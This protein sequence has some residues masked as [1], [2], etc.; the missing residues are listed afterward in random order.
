MPWILLGDMNMVFNQEEKIGGIPFK[1]AN[2]CYYQNIL[3]N[4]GL[5]DMG[6]KGFEFTWN[7]HRAGAANIQERLDRAVAN[8]ECNSK[9]PNAELTHQVVVGSDHSP[10]S[11][12]L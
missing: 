11:L 2:S 5:I 8:V 10:I 6:F 7:N 12:R 4:A 9:F 3:N 1:K